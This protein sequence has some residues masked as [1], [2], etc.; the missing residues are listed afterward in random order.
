MKNMGF[1]ALACITGLML[2]VQLGSL[3]PG[4]GIFN[5]IGWGLGAYM[6]GA[7][8]VYCAHAS[9]NHLTPRIRWHG[10]VATRIAIVLVVLVGA[11]AL[12]LGL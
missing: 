2:I 9:T 6:W 11:T 8:A 5:V 1:F 3:D 10:R 7:W 12:M 4:A